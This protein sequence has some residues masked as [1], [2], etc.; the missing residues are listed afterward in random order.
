MTH[1][2]QPSLSGLENTP[3]LAA[4]KKLS[5]NKWR[6]DWTFDT[7]LGHFVTKILDMD[8]TFQLPDGS[9]YKPFT[10]VW[11]VNTFFHITPN[12]YW[13]NPNPAVMDHFVS[14]IYRNKVTPMEKAILDPSRQTIR[15]FFEQNIWWDVDDSDTI[16]TLL[17]K[18]DELADKW[19][20][21]ITPYECNDLKAWIIMN[22]I[23]MQKTL[24]DWNQLSQQEKSQYCIKNLDKKKFTDYFV[25][26]VVD[27]PWRKNT[28]NP[29]NH[30]RDTVQ[31]K[32][33][34][35]YKV[36]WNLVDNLQEATYNQ[37][38][39]TRYI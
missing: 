17:W 7:T 24:D 1:V 28:D 14:N 33:H 10:T 37:F 9:K 2:N 39:N 31:R 27:L 30:I 19:I 25:D 22:C 15:E 26:I 16:D 35:L 36:D 11:E 34:A 20:K 21:N 18:I 3:E 8:I 23:W 5:K 32:I 12:Q 4:A 38:R 29:Y 13:T 6:W